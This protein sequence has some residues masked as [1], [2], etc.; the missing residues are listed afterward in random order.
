MD[1]LPDL[2]WSA[3]PAL[4]SRNRPRLLKAIPH[5][6]RTL[7]EGLESINYSSAQ[8]EAF[9]QTLMD[10]HMA[11]YKPPRNETPPEV[12]SSRQFDATPEPWMQ[13]MEARNSGFMD[14]MA[15]Q[16]AP[17][18]EETELIQ[19]NWV[20]IKAEMDSKSAQTLPV[21]TW[22]DIWQEGHALRC[23]ITWASPHGTMFLFTA[24]DGRSLSMT[25]RGLER[26]LEQDR[27]RV[28]AEHGVLD[29]ALDAVARQAWINSAKQ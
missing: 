23:Q 15:I 20:D 17:A 19:R 1:I 2:L 13:P 3:Q 29:S 18:F 24:S 26:L 10:L 22:V 4:A 27:L 6:L 9:F 21:G 25:R 14:D 11:A 12:Q 7:R 5:V 16:A 28:V 8:T